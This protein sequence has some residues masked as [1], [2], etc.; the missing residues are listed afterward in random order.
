MDGNFLNSPLGLAVQGPMQ[1]DPR[2]LSDLPQAQPAQPQGRVTS[3]LKFPRKPSFGRLED[4]EGGGGGGGG[5]GGL[6]SG[7]FKKISKKSIFDQT[8]F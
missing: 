1:Y 8:N 6:E 7:R 5:V 3:G 4:E 2:R